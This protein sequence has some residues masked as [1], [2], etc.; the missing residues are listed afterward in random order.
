M[1]RVLRRNSS[2]RWSDH[3]LDDARRTARSGNDQRLAQAP[4]RPWLRYQVQDVGRL[5]KQHKQ[6]QKMMKKV[7]AK[8]G[9]AKM[10]RGM[11]SMFPGG[12]PKL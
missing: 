9:M 7:T 2:S 12:M 4:H 1:P 11:G 3:Q 8:G 6:M 10:M 5:I